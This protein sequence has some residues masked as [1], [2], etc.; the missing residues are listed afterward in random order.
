MEMP[1]TRHCGTRIFPIWPGKK[2]HGAAQGAL[3]VWVWSCL[4][5][6]RHVQIQQIWIHWINP[7][8]LRASSIRGQPTALPLL[9]PKH[10]KDNERE[11]R[12][13]QNRWQK[14]LASHLPAMPR[15]TLFS[16]APLLGFVRF[17]GLRSCNAYNLWFRMPPAK[18]NRPT[19]LRWIP[20]R[21]CWRFLTCSKRWNDALVALHVPL[22]V[23]TS[24]KSRT[25]ERLKRRFNAWRSPRQSFGGKLRGTNGIHIRI[26]PK[27][28]LDCRR[29]TLPAML[30]TS[31]W[32][33]NDVIF[34]S[35][36]GSVP[37][38]KGNPEGVLVE[39]LCVPRLHV[40]FTI[41][42]TFWNGILWA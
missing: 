42:A 4:A 5:G 35:A 22:L 8:C 34:S 40:G 9:L 28:M 31:W 1:F 6:N 24:T 19:C 7:N 38:P 11:I 39:C 41:H 23:T 10:K 13:T 26:L 30:A 14:I 15:K 32:L 18:S 20:Q 12:L 21:S 33:G 17:Q 37:W 36:N 16:F 3:F 25:C 27:C 2:D 29:R